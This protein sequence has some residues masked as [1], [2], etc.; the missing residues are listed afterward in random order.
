[1]PSQTH[2]ARY[3]EF[4]IVLEQLNDMAYLL[5]Y[6]HSGRYQL[7]AVKML[8]HFDSFQEASQDIVSLKEQCE[9]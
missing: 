5:F 7:D 9:R 3:D 4:R 2:Q 8:R 6:R 1:M